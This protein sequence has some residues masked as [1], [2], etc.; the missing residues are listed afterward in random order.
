MRLEKLNRI[1]GEAVV[2][3]EFRTR[4]LS[5][6][7]TAVAGFD[8]A[9]D[10]LDLIGNLHADSV[11]QLAQHLVSALSLDDRGFGVPVVRS[12]AKPVAE[13]NYA[14]RI[15]ADHTSALKTTG[16]VVRAYMSPEP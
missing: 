15:R 10:E 3:C 16:P 14:C 9:A 6:P 7:R 8:L 1:V 4:L 2:N 12:G 5:D 13:P 11:D